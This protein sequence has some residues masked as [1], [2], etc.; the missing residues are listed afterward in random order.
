M[1]ELRQSAIAL[2]LLG[3]TAILVN[4]KALEAGAYAS[5]DEPRADAEVS[6]RKASVKSVRDA[7]LADACKKMRDFRTAEGRP[8]N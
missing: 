2:G 7:R 8:W 3:C 1:M 6:C 5:V 4:T